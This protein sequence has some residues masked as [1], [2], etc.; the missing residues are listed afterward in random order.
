MSQGKWSLTPGWCIT[1][2]TWT[3]HVE[4]SAHG[5]AQPCNHV[6]FVANHVPQANLS[7]SAATNLEITPCQ[8]QS[9]VLAHTDL[10]HKFGNYS[11]RTILIYAKTTND[12]LKKHCSQIM[13]IWF[14]YLRVDCMICVFMRKETNW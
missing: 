8:S 6:T 3:R 12:C 1:N 2:E 11:D 7:N 5:D 13:I 14:E 4:R 9:L 10:Y